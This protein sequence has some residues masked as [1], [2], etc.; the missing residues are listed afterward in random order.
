MVNV[1]DLIMVQSTSSGKG[2]QKRYCW[3]GARKGRKGV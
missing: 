2:E 3:V 1:V